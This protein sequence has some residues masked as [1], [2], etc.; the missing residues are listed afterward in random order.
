MQSQIKSI[1]NMG[2]ANPRWKGSTRVW[3]SNPSWEGPTL[4]NRSMQLQCPARKNRFPGIAESEL[5]APPRPGSAW[6]WVRSSSPGWDPP[7]QVPFPFR[8]PWWESGWKLGSQSWTYPGVAHNAADHTRIRES[9]VVLS[10][11]TVVSRPGKL[12]ELKN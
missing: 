3:G 1:E 11:L 2:G 8:D 6:T 5:V 9:L 10:G 12:G 4:V 7:D